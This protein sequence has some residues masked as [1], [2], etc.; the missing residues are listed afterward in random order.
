[1]K[2]RT[3]RGSIGPCSEEGK[4]AL[5]D[6]TMLSLWYGGLNKVYVRRFRS[7]GRWF[8]CPVQETN[9]SREFTRIWASDNPHLRVFAYY[10][11]AVWG[12]LGVAS[13]ALF[14]GNWYLV[15]YVQNF[16]HTFARDSFGVSFYVFMVVFILLGIPHLMLSLDVYS[17]WMPRCQAL[18]RALHEG[19]NAHAAG[20]FEAMREAGKTLFSNLHKQ[21]PWTKEAMK[22]ENAVRLL[23]TPFYLGGVS[24]VVVSHLI[25]GEAGGRRPDCPA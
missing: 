17:E 18:S 14:L 8:F 21:W 22:R 6:E 16:E 10:C 15:N 5:T 23:G 7:G 9:T 20:F 24:A 2:M 1:M 12:I 25:L 13:A 11:K 19:R 3:R 4:A